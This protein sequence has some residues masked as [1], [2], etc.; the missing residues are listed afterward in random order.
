MKTSYFSILLLSASF[1]GSQAGVLSTVAPSNANPNGKASLQDAA[2]AE[3]EGIYSDF[4]FTAPSGVSWNLDGLSLDVTSDDVGT[5]GGN[6]PLTGSDVYVQTGPAFSFASATFVASATAVGGGAFSYPSSIDLS[7]LS[8]DNVEKV[9]FRVYG[10]RQGSNSNQTGGISFG[11]ATLSGTAVPEISSSIP[12]I[13][14]FY[15]A[16]FGNRRRRRV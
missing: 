14:L 11:S 15:F 3:S 2:D 13:G 6:S 7:G 5:T 10:H 4:V 16:L 8:L 12:L 9:T 1:C